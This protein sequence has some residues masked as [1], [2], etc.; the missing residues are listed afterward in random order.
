MTTKKQIT[1]LLCKSASLILIGFVFGLYSH[2]WFLQTMIDQKE[3]TPTLTTSLFCERASV[4]TDLCSAS[5]ID[6]ILHQKIKGAIKDDKEEL[7]FPLTLR[8]E[9]SEMF[10]LTNT[11]PQNRYQH[12]ESVFGVNVSSLDELLMLSKTEG[13]LKISEFEKISY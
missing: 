4:Y 3:P 6:P 1:L 10:T 8:V 2:D 9:V 12:S 5:N 7:L 11:F 13:V